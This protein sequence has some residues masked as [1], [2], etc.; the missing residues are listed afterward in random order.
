MTTPRFL[1]LWGKHFSVFHSTWKP[2]V[3][4]TKRL[5]IAE[6]STQL[7]GVS[8][9]D[10]IRVALNAKIACVRLAMKGMPKGNEKHNQ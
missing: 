9:E 4:E 1:N 8:P 6:Q 10:V 3:H 5:N 2:H 7:L